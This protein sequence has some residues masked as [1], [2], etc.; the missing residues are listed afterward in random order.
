MFL[1]RVKLI[2]QGEKRETST[3]TC[4][5]TML[6]DKL[7]VFVSRLS[8]PL[9]HS[10]I[11]SKFLRHFFNQSEVKSKPN[12]ACACTFSRPLCRLCVITSSFDWFTGLSPSFLIGQ[13]N[14]F[15]FGLRHSI[16]I[17][18]IFNIRH[19]VIN[20]SLSLQSGGPRRAAVAF[21]NG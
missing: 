15:G 17:R 8:P 12:V 19:I 18:S 6:R 5:E 14:Y 21:T 13:S 20:N 11:G 9:L 4:N 7:R 16:E 10:V 1:L 3:K 2:T